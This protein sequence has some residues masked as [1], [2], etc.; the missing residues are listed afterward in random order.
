MRYPARAPTDGKAVLEIMLDLRTFGG[1]SCCEP[2]PQELALYILLTMKAF[3]NLNFGYFCNKQKRKVSLHPYLWTLI[4]RFRSR[5]NSGINWLLSGDFAITHSTCT[6]LCTDPA[7]PPCHFFL[8]CSCAI[9]S[10]EYLSDDQL[11]LRISDWSK[12]T[13]SDFNLKD[14]HYRHI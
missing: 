11:P 4:F 14:S 6:G 5:S 12:K 10:S 3:R 2:K 8:M 7:D 13:Y 9:F 1:E